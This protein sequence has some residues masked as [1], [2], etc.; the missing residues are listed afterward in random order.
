MCGGRHTWRYICSAY[1][2]TALLEL[3]STRSMQRVSI[4]AIFIFLMSLLVVSA[5][6][7]PE[8]SSLSSSVPDGVDKDSL[9]SLQGRDT[10][11]DEQP[12]ARPRRF[13]RPRMHP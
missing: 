2:Y 7:P 12:K 6:V 1:L 9:S 4:I 13:F 3:N 10:I 5:L 8:R 11:P